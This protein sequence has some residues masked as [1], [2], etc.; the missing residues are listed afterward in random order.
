M[1]RLAAIAA[2]LLTAACAGRP[3]P[4]PMAPGAGVPAPAASSGPSTV[5]VGGED[6]GGTSDTSPCTATELPDGEVSW[7]CTGTISTKG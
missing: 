2:L 7:R 6:A 5:L 1:Y 3:A 4:A